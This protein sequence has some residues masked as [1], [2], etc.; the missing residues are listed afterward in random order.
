MSYA[1]PL[2]TFVMA[3]LG[4][5]W[6]LIFIPFR[7]CGLKLYKISDRS[8]YTR[9]SKIILDKVIIVEDG[10]NPMGFFFSWTY[11]GYADNVSIGNKSSCSIYIL[12][13]KSKYNELTRDKSA[14][15]DNDHN[16]SYYERSGCFYRISY[17][18]HVYPGFGLTP[19]A[20][21]NRIISNIKEIYARRNYV[22]AYIHGGPGC[23]KSTIAFILASEMKCSLCRSYCPTDP[24]DTLRNL[25]NVVAPTQEK[26]LIVVFEEADGMLREIHNNAVRHHNNLP[27]E[28]TSKGEWSNFWD[29]MGFLYPNV[30]CILTS[31]VDPSEI[32]AMDSSYIRDGRIDI[33]MLLE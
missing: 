23:G 19:T 9:V 2:I 13:T 29:N 4:I 17:K 24:N 30:I 6:S 20:N 22:S 12:T 28:I 3:T 5:I 33:K 15:S 26:P 16:I 7:I 25:Y 10:E 18:E 27:T 8:T 1:L 11:C 21:Q 32:N 14:N 31:N